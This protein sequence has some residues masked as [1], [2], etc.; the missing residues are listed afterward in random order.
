MKTSAIYGSALGI[1]ALVGFSYS[2]VSDSLDTR[3]IK[4]NVNGIL[5]GG[6]EVTSVKSSE[7][8]GLVEVTIQDSE[9][10][11]VSTDGKY[12]IAGDL[13]KFTD[14]G[15]LENLTEKKRSL[16]RKQLMEDYGDTG[17]ISY[18]AKNETVRVSVFTDIDCPYCR[19]L[20]DM[21]GDYNDL[22][23]SIDY[24]AFP[25]AG[26]DS[27]S[28]EKHSAVWC[29][30]DPAQALSIAKSGQPVTA[31]SCDDPVAEHYALGVSAG[32]TGTPSIVLENGDMIGGLV[33]PEQLFEMAR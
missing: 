4:H 33:S 10:V 11:Y 31:P 9:V 1:V 28:G 14:D 6:A 3:D 30:D 12:L 29:S 16:K 32:V 2:A 18:P 21:I 27:A 26:V 17:V 5:N 24:Y 13:M 20:H 8:D 15:A 25:R 19:K 22:G 23:I 7:V